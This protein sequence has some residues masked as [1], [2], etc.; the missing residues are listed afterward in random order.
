MR[1]D[2]YLKVSR[3]IKRRTVAKEACESGRVIINGKVA[4]PSNDIK[5]GDIIEILFGNRTLKARVINITEHVRKE[6]AKEM[7]E[8]LEGEEDKE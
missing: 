5:E 4:K 8:I 7:Y 2:K 3:I 6:N 1:L